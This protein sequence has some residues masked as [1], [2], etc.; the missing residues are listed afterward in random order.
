MGRHLIEG[1][2]DNAVSSKTPLEDLVRQCMVLAVTLNHEPLRVWSR[3]ELDGYKS[4]LSLPDY[5][6]VRVQIRHEGDSFVKAGSLASDRYIPENLRRVLLTVPLTHLIAELEVRA[7]EG[8]FRYVVPESIFDQIEDDSAWD[9]LKSA[10]RD[11]SASSVKSLLSTIR[12]RDLDFVLSLVDIRLQP[13]AES[14]DGQP[15]SVSTIYDRFRAYVLGDQNVVYVA[16]QTALI[17]A[18]QIYVAPGDV[19]ALKAFSADQGAG[20]AD[21]KQLEGVVTASKLSDLNDSRSA[22]CRWIKKAAKSIATSGG[23]MAETAA[24][25]LVLLSIRYSFGDVT[26]SQGGGVS[27]ST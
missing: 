5:R 6:L 16:G 8:G 23:K 27:G 1:I 17:N 22:L 15:V 12:N 25:E 10:Y 13:E 11:I 3:N 4:V 21:I 2:R 26:G 18:Q 14:P 24:K 19:T 7:K 20:D 9:T